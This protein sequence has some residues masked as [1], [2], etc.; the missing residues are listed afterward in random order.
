MWGQEGHGAV[1]RGRDVKAL[2][3]RA[4]ADAVIA[5]FTGAKKVTAKVPGS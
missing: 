4:D 5:A 1:L 2:D 3:A